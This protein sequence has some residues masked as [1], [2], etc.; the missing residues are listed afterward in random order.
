MC[1]CWL[2]TCCL[3][4]LL[5]HDGK[6]YDLQNLNDLLCAV[7]KRGLAYLQSG[8]KTRTE[9][10]DCFKLGL[11]VQICDPSCPGMRQGIMYVQGQICIT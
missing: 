9:T 11:V 6:P 7:W 10:I 1:V 8:R 5:S 2:F 3:W 4:L